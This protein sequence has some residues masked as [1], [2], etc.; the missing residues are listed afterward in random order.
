MRLLKCQYAANTKHKLIER[1]EL[2]SLLFIT[3]KTMEYATRKFV[4]VFS[5]YMHHLVLRLP[6]VNHKRQVILYRPLDMLL[7]SLQLFLFHFTAP[8][9]IKPDLTYRYIRM[10]WNKPCLHI[11]KNSFKISL[12][13]FRMKTYHRISETL[14]RCAQIQ[15]RL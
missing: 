7:E 13:L 2:C 15:T 4:L 5:K 12:Y 11:R 9:I 1:Q 3:C 8:I 6:A 14:I 10:L